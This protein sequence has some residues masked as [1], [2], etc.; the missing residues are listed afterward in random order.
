MTEAKASGWSYSLLAI[1]ITI[2]SFAFLVVFG[3]IGV[4][5]VEVSRTDWYLY[6]SYLVSP[7][8]FGC[9][10]WAVLSMTKTPLQAELKE[11]TCKAKYFLLAVLLQI[12][13]LSLSELN[14]LFLE[15]LSIFG[16]ENAGLSIPS[17]NGMGFVG[18]LF[19]VAVLP[20]IFEEWVFRGLLLKGMHSFGRV[21]AVLI[22]GALFALY[23]QNPAQTVYQFCCGVGFALVALRAGS[24][25]PAVVS[26]FI[27]NAL[28]ITLYKFGVTTFAPPVYIIILC[29]SVVCLA[30]ALLWL[31]VFDKQ[32][33]KTQENRE[34]QKRFWMGAM[35]GIVIFGLVWLSVL[36][37]GI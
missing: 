36:F 8:A 15:F 17:L 4:N 35:L 27:N 2:A 9:T 34:E 32:A 1:A 19:V 24:F 25:L 33:E 26:H 18:V 21:G 11:Q 23:H 10:V 20:A 22:S 3:A 37:K 30:A 12:G 7:L 29:V 13:L 6:C 14:S 31:F 16:Y 28:I 5:V